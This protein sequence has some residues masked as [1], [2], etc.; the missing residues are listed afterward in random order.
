LLEYSYKKYSYIEVLLYEETDRKFRN[1]IFEEGC[2]QLHN[3]N[4]GQAM[5]ALYVPDEIN[6]SSTYESCVSGVVERS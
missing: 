1:I 3:Y 4:C 6:R 5:V 2:S